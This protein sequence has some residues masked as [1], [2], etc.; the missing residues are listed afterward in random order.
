RPRTSCSTS[1]STAT[2]SCSTWSAAACPAAPCPRGGRR[3]ASESGGRSFT[4]CACSRRERHSAERLARP[5]RVHRL[6]RVGD[7]ALGAAEG[8]RDVEA[9]VEAAEVLRRLERLLER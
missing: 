4:T 3:S 6:Q 8:A 2:A 1:R 9:A 5:R 7:E